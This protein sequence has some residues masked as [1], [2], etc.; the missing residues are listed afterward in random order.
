MTVPGYAFVSKR[1]STDVK[2]AATLF[3]V[4]FAFFL[5]IMSGTQYSFDGLFMFQQARTLVGQHTLIFPE[6]IRWNTLYTTSKYGIGMSLAYLPA[7]IPL[8]ILRPA[9]FAPNFFD[10]TIPYNSA[11]IANKLYLYSSWLNPLLTSLLGVVLYGLARF[12][13]M[14][15]RASVLTVLIMGMASPLTTQARYDFAQPLVALLLCAGLLFVLLALRRGQMRYWVLTG[16]CLGYGFLTRP[17]Y[18][19]V[20]F[21]IYLL[22]LFTFDHETGK[23]KFT[24]EQIKGMVVMSIPF[25]IGIAGSL[26]V[27]YFRYGSFFN[28]GYDGAFSNPGWFIGWIGVLVSP[29]TG[30]F[31]F[32]PLALLGLVMLWQL[33][34][35]KEVVAIA[36][37]GLCITFW[38]FFGMWD[39]WWGGWS[40]GPRFLSPVIPLLTLYA[41]M[42]LSRQSALSRTMILVFGALTVV[43]FLAAVN[44]TLFNPLSF[45]SKYFLTLTDEQVFRD[46]FGLA[47]S[48]LFAGWDWRHRIDHF[49]LWWVEH[50][51]WSGNLPSRIAFIG[52][53]G[54]VGG[55]GILLLRWL[56]L[57]KYAAVWK[58]VQLPKRTFGY[59]LVPIAI[60]LVLG[61]TRTLN[62]M[63]L[64][65]FIDE[66][67]HT[68][69]GHRF[70]IGQTSEAVETGRLGGVAIFAFA[71]L[72]ASNA[73]WVNR[74]TAVAFGTLAGVGCF[75]LGKQLFS[76]RVGLVAM[77]LY[78]L[79]P[80]ALVFDRMALI[81]VMLSVTGV[82]IILL[83]MRLITKPTGIQVVAVGLLIGAAVLL[84]T[85]GIVLVTVPALAFLIL[86]HT[87]VSWRRAIVPVVGAYL[88][89]VPIFV[90]ML[91]KQVGFTLGSIFLGVGQPSLTSHLFS[92]DRNIEFWQSIFQYSPAI[93]VLTLLAAA[94]AL[95]TRNRRALYLSAVILVVFAFA[96]PL[97]TIYPRYGL[98]ALISALV[99]SSYVLVRASEWLRQWWSGRNITWN[100]TRSARLQNGFLA[101]CV[102]LIGA[103]GLPISVP[104]LTDPPSAA[105]PS[106]ERTQYIDGW[107]SGYGYPEAV[108]YLSTLRNPAKPIIILTPS[109]WGASQSVDAYYKPAVGMDL[110][111]LD[112]D[113]RTICKTF[114]PDNRNRPMYVI[115][116]APSNN[117]LEVTTW[118]AAHLD[119][120][121]FKP[122][123]LNQVEV[124]QVDMTHAPC[125]TA[126]R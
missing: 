52:L 118:Q 18:V 4:L 50:L 12:L 101:S 58:R 106:L 2:I 87:N 80:F 71:E 66:A 24:L 11:L 60:L 20:A 113:A 115:M 47:A 45:Y 28:F 124:W 41:V 38:L 57:I 116:S 109:G 79:N 10:N 34:R 83:S 85:N 111:T 125:E 21:W 39:A 26:V 61:I 29:G 22:C 55:G 122:G 102:L 3:A 6:P 89:T 86:P 81:D 64:P 91:V 63:I 37:V 94:L 49:D 84:K 108:N 96:A 92:F 107:P 103:A 97:L 19:L 1:I 98:P 123:N 120:T 110:Y 114:P 70:F 30:L 95:W 104:L 88:V 82:F 67:L 43:G 15:R 5:V 72:F 27:N 121:F 8:S 33:V 14:G 76:R 17:D 100:S 23:F 117:P 126:A 40:F 31:I 16:V 51:H 65:V 13:K 93:L 78:V 112:I 99:L 25:A 48:P 90:F 59:F 54:I 119:R 7:L 46:H 68:A 56:D 75:A 62:L 53:L 77:A 35:Q 73:L 42:W 32:F 44:G 9:L 69:W 74:L 105:L 36:V